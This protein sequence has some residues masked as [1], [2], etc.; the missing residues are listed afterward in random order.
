VRR[1]LVGLVAVAALTAGCGDD[2]DTAATASAT[3]AASTSATTATTS[4]VGDDPLPPIVGMDE[5]GAVAIDAGGNA[6]W[7]TIAAGAAWVANVGGGV[8]RY[9]L[10][11]GAEVGTSPVPGP[12]CLAM[13][14]GFDSLWAGDCAD[15]TIVRIDLATGAVLATIAPGF[16]T[17]AEESSIAVDDH[18]VYV[19]STGRE[20]RVARI[21]PATDTAVGSFAAP[22]GAAAMRAG[23]GS[24]WVT[25][26]GAGAVTR[27]DADDGSE[28]STVPTG[29]GA[30][31]LAVGDDAVWVLNNGAGT[32]TRVDPDGNAVATITVGDEPVDGGDIAVGGASVWARVTDAV[33]ARIDVATNAVVARYG[34]PSGSGSVAADDDVA[35]ISA[36][37]IAT[38]WRL[39]LG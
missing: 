16:D 34:E 36:H 39:P 25:Q 2:D 28:L 9:D 22:A 30:R 37:D 1:A 33:V 7:V 26:P 23:F 11:T 14:V 19:M 29:A 27:V 10:R 21:D 15:N 5:A 4:I 17:I 13:E 3:V 18:C 31:F 6:D 20:R 32:V 38:V 24:L 35:W 8:T 12:V